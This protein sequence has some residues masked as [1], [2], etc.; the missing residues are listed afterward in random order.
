VDPV[1]AFTEPP[2][3]FSLI[4]YP[5][6]LPLLPTTGLLS[7]LPT[8]YPLLPLVDYFD[9]V[10]LPPPLLPLTEFVVDGAV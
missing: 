1:G 10:V 9:F 7:L 6:E 4:G 5:N 2:P 8:F 3:L